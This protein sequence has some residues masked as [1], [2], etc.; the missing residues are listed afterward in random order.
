MV[1]FLG[2]TRAYQDALPEASEAFQ[3]ELD[4]MF[5]RWQVEF[6]KGAVEVID[7]AGVV[8][9][10]V[11]LGLL[12]FR[13]SAHG[14]A[15]VMVALVWRDRRRADDVVG[16]VIRVGAVVDIRPVGVRVGSVVVMRPIEAESEPD[17]EPH[18]DPEPH[19]EPGAIVAMSGT[20]LWG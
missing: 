4:V 18:S 8:A 19:T 7:D 9:I 12:W 14:S 3:S 16:T 1:D 13:E 6:L 20:S 5:S 15:P 2:V 11:D 17:P 10:D